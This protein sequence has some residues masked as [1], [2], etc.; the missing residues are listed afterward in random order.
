M[1]QII[2]PLKP[3]MQG[4]DVGNLQT[5]LSLLKLTIAD[6]EKT[7]QRYGASTR[8]AVSQFQTEHQLQVTGAVDEA[9]AGVMNNILAELGVLSVQ[10]Y[11]T[12]NLEN[13]NPAAGVQLVLSYELPAGG[14]WTS[15]PITADANGKLTVD[16]PSASPDSIDWSRI[17]F[18]F[19]K[20]DKPLRVVDKT[21][22]E[23][24]QSGFA[25]A[26][27][28]GQDKIPWPPPQDPNKWYVRGRVSTLNGEAV[29]ANVSAA[30]IS[31]SGEKPLG[32]AQTSKTGRYEII[33]EWDGKCSPDIQ[34]SANVKTNPLRNRPSILPW[35]SRFEST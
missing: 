6:A 14:T 22:P 10:L 9:T 17:G 11:V 7:A 18:A 26:I 4:P 27:K 31:L 32:Q 19:S 13:G 8:Q 28:L 21:P 33:Y 23:P 29:L 25:I 30:C 34:V 24:V 12:A 15:Q 20:N 1:K 5:A 3:R 2:F 35:A 16:L